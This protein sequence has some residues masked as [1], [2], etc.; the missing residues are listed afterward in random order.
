MP[1]ESSILGFTNEW[2]ARAFPSA[3]EVT[4][5]SG[6][7]IR[8][9][10]PPYLLATKLEAFATRGNSDFY[11]SRDFGDVVTL[12]DG[13]EELIR[14]VAESPAELRAYL[15][16]QIALHRRHPLFWSGV[17]GALP[18]SPETPDRVNEVVRPRFEQLIDSV[19]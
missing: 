15:A 6:R 18:A 8:A 12:V 19:L 3:I 7:T 14:E 17:E 9:I 13:R 10:S 1:T 16:A 4:L 11:A 5:A 2:Q